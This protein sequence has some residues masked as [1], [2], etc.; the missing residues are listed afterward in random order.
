MV[1]ISQ[2]ALALQAFLTA[3]TPQNEATPEAFPLQ[4]A[5]RVAQLWADVLL[6]GGQKAAEQSLGEPIPFL[7]DG[8]AVVAQNLGIHLICPHHLT[9]A[10]GFAHIAFAPSDR[11]VGFGALS[12]LAQAATSQLVL[13][14]HATQ[15]IAQTLQQKL[16]AR[17]GVVVL[18]AVHP[19]H[20]LTQPQAH[21]AR[22]VTQSHFG[23]KEDVALL[24]PQIPLQASCQQPHSSPKP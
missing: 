5:K 7:A 15:T 8:D 21:Q 6:A 17:A 14:E 16:G 10:F 1:D 11:T 23:P 13:Q 3:L 2:A 20:N 12:R 4:S 9:V 19:C 18:E 24:L 22:I